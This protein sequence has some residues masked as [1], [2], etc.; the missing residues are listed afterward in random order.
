MPP[1]GIHIKFSDVNRR[2]QYPSFIIH[3]G[4]FYESFVTSPTAVT[5]NTTLLCSLS[6][7][8]RSISAFNTLPGMIIAAAN[9]D[10]RIV[11][12]PTTIYA[13]YDI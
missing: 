1:Q 7:K 13:Y 10:T 8:V 4:Y 3:E 11:Q 5:T 12:Q 9:E 2:N 6:T